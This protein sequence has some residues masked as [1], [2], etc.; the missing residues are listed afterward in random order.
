MPTCSAIPFVQP[1]PLVQNISILSD[2]TPQP[3]VSL[4]GPVDG[5]LPASVPNPG[6]EIDFGSGWVPASVLFYFSQYPEDSY[7]D[8]F[9]E[10]DPVGKPWRLTS[11]ASTWTIGGQPLNPQSGTVGVYG[12]AA[13]IAEKSLLTGKPKSRS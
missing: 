7:A 2:G 5:G 9:G 10:A 12:P 1:R 6:I 13:K 8:G 4:T 11:P 3:Y